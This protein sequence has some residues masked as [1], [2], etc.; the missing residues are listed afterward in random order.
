MRPQADAGAGQNNHKSLR[1]I[2][3]V[4]EREAKSSLVFP[5][6]LY[7]LRSLWPQSLRFSLP[8][9]S[10]TFPIINKLLRFQQATAEE[11]TLA[12]RRAVPLCLISAI[13]C[14]FSGTVFGNCSNVSAEL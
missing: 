1:R 13:V 9:I 7:S 2:C 11:H 6:P 10:P 5:F 4:G 14:E 12:K 8:A 3:G